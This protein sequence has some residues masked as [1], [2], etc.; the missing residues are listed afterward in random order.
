MYTMSI[1]HKREPTIKKSSSL[2][3]HVQCDTHKIA[4]ANSKAPYK[5]HANEFDYGI[6]ILTPNLSASPTNEINHT[7]STLH[8]IMQKNN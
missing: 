6:P 3:L 1:T 2:N 4:P 7:R 5:I 8:P